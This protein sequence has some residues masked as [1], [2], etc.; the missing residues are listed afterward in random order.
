M[1]DEKNEI[2]RLQERISIL[3]NENRLLKERLQESENLRLQTK[4][5]ATF[6]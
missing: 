1:D 4:W 3:E 6:S 2:L 5:Q